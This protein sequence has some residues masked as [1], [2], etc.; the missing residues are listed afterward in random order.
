[1]TTRPSTAELWSHPEKNNHSRY[2]QLISRHLQIMQRSV[3]C[4]SNLT[5]VWCVV[6][7]CVLSALSKKV[8]LFKKAHCKLLSHRT[9]STKRKWVQKR[10]SDSWGHTRYIAR[11]WSGVY[12][13]CPLAV[14][15]L[16]GNLGQPTYWE[17]QTLN[18]G[19]V[20]SMLLNDLEK[21]FKLRFFFCFHLFYEVLYGL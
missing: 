13:S 18:E 14:K 19:T 9:T 17:A 5:V 6:V 11:A 12:N 15:E 3:Q 16:K 2:L 1:M 7:N 8:Y 20:S 21:P 4:F 10:I